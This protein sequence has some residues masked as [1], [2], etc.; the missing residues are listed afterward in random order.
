M[1]LYQSC[2][3]KGE[4]SATGQNWKSVRVTRDSRTWLTVNSTERAQDRLSNISGATRNTNVLDSDQVAPLSIRAVEYSRV[5]PSSACL[6]DSGSTRPVSRRVVGSSP[7]FAGGGL[8]KS[9]R[10][11][12]SKVRTS[13]AD[14]PTVPEEPMMGDN[15]MSGFQNQSTIPKDSLESLMELLARE[16]GNCDHFYK[17]N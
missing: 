11:S 1:P 12:P 3:R 7:F 9:S 10:K 17:V 2:H 4:A 5:P 15:D 8:M 13:Y 6:L 16:H 14:S